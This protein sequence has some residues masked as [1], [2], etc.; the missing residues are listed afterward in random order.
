MGNQH[1]VEMWCSNCN[2]WVNIKMFNFDNKDS[3]LK[4]IIFGNTEPCP[5]CNLIITHNKKH[6]RYIDDDG[7]Y[8][9][10]EGCKN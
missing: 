4:S 1:H 10:I 7:I 3:F 5:I 8:W 9:Y 6:L 2:D